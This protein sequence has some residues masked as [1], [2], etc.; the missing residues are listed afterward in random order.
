MEAQI[1][2]IAAASTRKHLLILSIRA[3]PPHFFL[4]GSQ[5]V[6]AYPRMVVWEKDTE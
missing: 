6:S 2:M 5:G 4:S 3:F 1:I